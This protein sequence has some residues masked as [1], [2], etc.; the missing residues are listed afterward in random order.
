M[1]DNKGPRTETGRF[2]PSGTTLGPYEL[3]SLVGSGGMGEVYQAH[4]SRLGRDVAVKVLPSAVGRDPER[5]R[6]F[7]IEARAT[8]ALSHP[9]IL[10]VY[11]LGW[12]EGAPYLVT[13]L[14]EGEDLRQRLAG[15]A[16]TTR[17]AVEVAIQAA[18]ALSFAHDRNIVHRDLKPG[19][20]FVTHDGQLKILDFG[21][22]RLAPHSSETL[23]SLAATEDEGTAAGTVLGTVGYMAPEQVRGE[24]ADSRSDIFSLGVVLYE[25][26]AKRAPF[27]RATT[28]ET[29]SAVLRD[30]PP[31]LPSTA[32]DANPALASIVERCLAKRPE[33]RFQSAHDLALALEAVSSP[34]WTESTSGEPQL[35]RRR[36]FRI[37]AVTA[38]VVLALVAGAMLMR[39]FPSGNTP[40]AAPPEEVATPA[41]L[42]PQN[43]V[44]ILPFVNKTG[45]PVN[46]AMG[47]ALAARVWGAVAEDSD[48]DVVPMAEVDEALASAVAIDS[49]IAAA[50]NAFVEVSGSISPE[51]SG[52]RIQAVVRDLISGHL[53]PVEVVCPSEDTSECALQLA[54]GVAEVVQMRIAWPELLLML[55][56][57]PSYE[58]F[59]ALAVDDDEEAAVAIDPAIGIFQRR[60]AAHRQ[61]MRG[62]EDEAKAAV[63]DVLDTHRGSLS[64]YG[65][66]VFCGDLARFERNYAESLR[67]S[68]GALELE[69]SSIWARAR[70]ASAALDLNRPLEAAAAF[71]D[72]DPCDNFLGWLP[73]A[74]Y[75]AGDFDGALTAVRALQACFP[76]WQGL[77]N[78]EVLVLAALGRV[79]EMEK[80]VERVLTS[81]RGEDF[82]SLVA[83]ALLLSEASL[84][85]R[86]RGDQTAA[87]SLAERALGRYSRALDQWRVEENAE[88][89]VEQELPMVDLLWQAGRESEAS[90]LCQTLVE[91]AP[92]QLGVVDTRGILAARRGDRQQAEEVDA[93]LAAAEKTTRERIYAAY[94]RAC[95][96]AQLGELDRALDLLR[97]AI[98]LGFPDWHVI[99]RDPD[100]EPLHD[101]P[102]FQEL[103]RPKG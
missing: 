8:A 37:A 27:A 61:F 38:T 40:A 70:V 67:K 65:D 75:L 96:T 26:L 77:D 54:A 85:L 19:N 24:V 4:D 81:P 72:I 32:G 62:E 93:A 97:E 94:D 60:D 34:S 55:N 1:I 64:R 30:D 6:R 15:G 9:N 88:P 103:V 84:E 92:D 12:H 52:Y 53:R 43:R 91:R 42:P 102:T 95:I 21:L 49:S 87:R 20:L 50:V 66:S 44:V 90:E 82:E 79:D 31:P 101:N 16:V 63:Q 2:L 5:V 74:L 11:D 98:A 51:G 99:R 35:N 36:T 18:R 22:A 14:L 86:F 69:P 10:A 25:L 17:D 59:L 76:Q 80:V 41:P 89:S 47:Q 68:R 56:R 58:A 71:A 73:R 46:D 33:D 29:L 78:R 7:D 28:A 100:L 3:R 39:F 48:V 13:E 57:L 45:D 83:P 23:D